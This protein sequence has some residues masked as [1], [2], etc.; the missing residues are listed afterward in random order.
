[1]AGTWLT[2]IAASAAGR[3]AALAVLSVLLA[4]RPARA[5][6][7]SALTIASGQYG[8]RAGLPREVGFQVEIRGP[9]RLSGLRPAAGVLAGGNGGAFAFAGL[10]LE[11]PLPGGFLLSPGFAPGVVLADA[12][13]GLG[14][15]VE[16]RSSLELSLAVAAAARLGIGFSH[17]SNG[18]LARQNPGAETVLL[19]LTF[20]CCG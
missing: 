11:V 10:V 13:R 2:R 16:F 8:I 19:G 1:M 17:I 14:S 6:E 7:R 3:P 5:G 9:W 20:A 18:G 15:T 12:R 4:A